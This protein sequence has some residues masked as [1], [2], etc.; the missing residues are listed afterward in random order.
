MK[1]SFGNMTVELNIFDVS[2]Q[3]PDNDDISEVDTIE[4]LIENTWIQFHSEDIV[5]T[6]L[7]HF[8]DDFDCEGSFEEVNALLESTLSMNI[9]KWLPKVEHF[10]P[11][12]SSS[13]S[14]PSI[15]ES[16]KLDLKL[17]PDTLK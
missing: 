16:F 11:S 4:S 15:I 17:L 5:E 13:P 9:G 14:L 3:P 8:G 10:S 1:I 2:K 12:P 6:C 7:A